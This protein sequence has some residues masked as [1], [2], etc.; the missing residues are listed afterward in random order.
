[1][2]IFRSKSNF[3]FGLIIMGVVIIAEIVMIVGTPS[4]VTLPKLTTAFMAIIFAVAFYHFV[5]GIQTIKID[6]NGVTLEIAFIPVKSIKWNDII[7]AGLGKIKLS[8]NKY[9]KQLYVSSKRLNS[10]YIDDLCKY[11]YNQKI[12]WFDFDQKAQDML[13]EGLGMNS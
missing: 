2:R 8:K 7:E 9:A 12:I 4:H 11:R 5:D 1:M 10:D 13:A 6:E 3:V